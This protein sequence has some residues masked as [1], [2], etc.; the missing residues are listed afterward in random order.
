M[1]MPLPIGSAAA[2]SNAFSVHSGASNS[3]RQE[4]LADRAATAFFARTSLAA[5]S[6]PPLERDVLFRLYCERDFEVCLDA[7]L[8]ISVLQMRYFD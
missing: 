5:Q 4:N 7:A 1:T 2:I 8:F 3:E 6:Y